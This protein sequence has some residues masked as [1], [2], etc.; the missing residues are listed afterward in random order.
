MNWNSL[1][2][3]KSLKNGHNKTFT[4]TTFAV[5][6]ALIRFQNSQIT[7]EVFHQRNS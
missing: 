4:Q 7:A 5:I 6:L 2:V 3:S 1:N